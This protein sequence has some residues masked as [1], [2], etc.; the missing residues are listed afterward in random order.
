MVAS[1]GGLAD[2]GLVGVEVAEPR[3]TRSYDDDG[4]TQVLPLG[5]TTTAP[6]PAAPA[7]RTRPRLGRPSHA[8]PGRS[9]SAP[10]WPS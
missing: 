9:S 3:R 6:P 4:A 1:A 8:G 5:T 2:I 7:P 10:P